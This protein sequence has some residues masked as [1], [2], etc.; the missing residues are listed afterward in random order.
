MFDMLD[1]ISI[2]FIFFY[3]RL[4]KY[5]SGYFKGIFRVIRGYFQSS[6]RASVGEGLGVQF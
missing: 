2:A 4:L 6:N 3:N 1:L 5:F